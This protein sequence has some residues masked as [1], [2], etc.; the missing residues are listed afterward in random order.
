M[1]TLYQKNYFDTFGF[2]IIRNLFTKD[3][4]K[5]IEITMSVDG[6]YDDLKL[7]KPTLDRHQA[8][9]WEVGDLLAQWEALHNHAIREKDD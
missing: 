6:F 7:A 9:M 4:V 3:E 5:T 8:L 2:I 1:I